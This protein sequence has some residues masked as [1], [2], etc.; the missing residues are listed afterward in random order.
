MGYVLGLD[1]GTGALKGVLVDETGVIRHIEA[2]DYPLHSPKGGYNEQNPADWL[3]ACGALFEKFSCNVSD[4][5]AE[6]AGISFSG[7]MHSLVVT[8]EA[9]T[10]LRPAIL[11]ND[12]RNSAQ[13]K[14]IMDE[15]G[16][17]IIAITKNRALEGFT[18]PKILW[19][20]EHEPAIWEKVR[21]IFLPKDYLRYY[22]TGHSHMDYSDAAGTLLMDTTKKEWS[23]PILEKHNIPEVILPPLVES[24][25]CVGTLKPE[26]KATFGFE[27]EVRIF[28]GGADNAVSSLGSGL[29]DSHTALA[30]IGTSGVFLALEE[31]DHTRYGGKVHLFNH[32]LPDTYYAMGVTLA[33]GHSVSWFKNL[34]APEQSYDEFLRNIPNVP[35]G[36]NGLLFTPYISGERTPHVDSQIRGSFIGLSNHHTRDDLIRAVLEGVTF[37][38]KDSQ[39]LM[40]SLKGE[41]FKR[42][43]SVGGGAKNKT[44]LQMQADIFNTEVVSLDTEEGPG[45][46]AAILAAVG[47]GWFDS[48]E[49]CTNQVIRYG[50]TV[51]PIP[52]NVEKYNT[53]YDLYTKVYGA[54][55]DL[56]HALSI[57]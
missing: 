45:L 19:I 32:V 55:K 42:I 29:T 12:V 14:R 33:A 1:L 15:F 23:K 22:L 38:L 4:F 54:T 28:T 17:E 35:I 51:Q 9:G 3:T 8:D 37:S 2:C 47:L 31:E 24:S 50:T 48:F 39:Q 10:V 11:W 13:C 16:N 6:L 49:S 56:S 21:K 27:K 18:L 36:S 30:S 7:Q 5:Q 34:L 52:E 20:Q 44:W 46:G 43:I 25:A 57:L 40:T 53:V 41:E 26:I